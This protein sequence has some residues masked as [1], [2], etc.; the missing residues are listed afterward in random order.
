MKKLFS[1]SQQKMLQ[2]KRISQL[3]DKELNAMYIRAWYDNKYSINNLRRYAVVNKNN[4][5]IRSLDNVYNETR[6]NK[7]NLIEKYKANRSNKPLPGYY[8]NLRKKYGIK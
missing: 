5:T 6:P 8:A 1:R 2:N 3:S 4:N 7:E